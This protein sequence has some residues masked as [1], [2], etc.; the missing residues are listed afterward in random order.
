MDEA[1]ARRNSPVHQHYPVRAPLMFVSGD[2]ESAEYARQ[3]ELME[4]FW[5]RLN[6]PSEI[7]TFKG[8]NHFTMAHL[9]K[10]PSSRLTKA[11]VRMMGIT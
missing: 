10:E 4:K 3:A 9:L 6:Y 8:Y 7:V 5:H 1:E 11:I 2:I